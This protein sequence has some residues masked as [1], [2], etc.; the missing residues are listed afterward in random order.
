[1]DT[2]QDDIL[3]IPTLGSH[4]ADEVLSHTFATTQDILPQ[5]ATGDGLTARQPPS[6]EQT[7]SALGIVSTHDADGKLMAVFTNEELGWTMRVRFLLE[8]EPRTF[9]SLAG[10]L[11]PLLPT[12]KLGEAL[13]MCN[14]YALHYSFGRFSVRR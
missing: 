1:M 6:I 3:V 13:L 11:E 7:L 2:M 8:G 5:S 4:R 9:F 12:P 10:T 14:V